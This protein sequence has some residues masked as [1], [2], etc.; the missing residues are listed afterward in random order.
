MSWPMKNTRKLRSRNRLPRGPDAAGTSGAAS[1][2]TVSGAS[3]HPE[4]TESAQLPPPRP[5]VEKVQCLLALDG[6]AFESE[7]HQERER[8][9][10]GGTRPDAQM[11]HDLVAVQRRPQGLEVLLLGEPGD[12]LLQVVLHG[13]ELLGLEPVPGG[14]VGSRELVEVVE[15]RAGVAHVAP[16]GAVAPARAPAGATA[17]ACRARPECARATRSPGGGASSGPPRPRAT[18]ASPR[19]APRSA[20]PGASATGRRRTPPPGRAA[21]PGAWP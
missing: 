4:P 12:A 3:I 7:L 19:A 16:H 6:P 15:Q 1:D 21:C 10:D 11:L 2:A 13:L 8:L 18:P 5:F 17:G 20:R 14:D 9:A